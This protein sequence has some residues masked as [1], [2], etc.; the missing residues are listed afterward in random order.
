MRVG[1]AG[2]L[3]VDGTAEEH[4]FPF[5]SYDKEGNGVIHMSESSFPLCRIYFQIIDC[6]GRAVTPT[7]R[8]TCSLFQLR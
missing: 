6:S 1:R 5:F 2:G 4:R 3:L 8:S 7:L